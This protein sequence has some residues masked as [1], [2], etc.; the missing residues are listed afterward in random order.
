MC[1]DVPNQAYSSRSSC[2]ASK[3]RLLPRDCCLC[4]CL[5]L[6]NMIPYV[7][8]DFFNWLLPLTCQTVQRYK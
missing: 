3:E 8:D 1:T 7:I 5:C 2:L 4:L 6:R